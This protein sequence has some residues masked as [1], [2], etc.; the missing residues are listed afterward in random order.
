M[1]LEPR[2]RK[3][4]L[5]KT[6]SPRHSP[7]KQRQQEQ[8]RREQIQQAVAKARPNDSSRDRLNAFQQ[9]KALARE[10][11]EDSSSSDEE[12]KDDSDEDESSDEEK[13]DQGKKVAETEV[14]P[15]SL[16]IEEQDH[17][18]TTHSHLSTHIKFAKVESNYS[19]TE[20]VGLK[21]VM[22]SAK[23]ARGRLHDFSW[24]VMT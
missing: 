12:A 19:S 1:V 2:Q 6:D 14:R 15:P 21:E 20:D 17:Q 7:S 5:E 18:D 16:Q 9:L 11:I 23:V 24:A 3:A 8:A 4:L 22:K 10:R 13:G